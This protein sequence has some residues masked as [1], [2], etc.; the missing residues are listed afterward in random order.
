MCKYIHLCILGSV[1]GWCYFCRRKRSQ[2]WVLKFQ[3]ISV[4]HTVCTCVRTCACVCVCVCVYVC[5]TTASRQYTR[6]RARAHALAK[7]KNKMRLNGRQAQK[8]HTNRNSNS[9]GNNTARSFLVWPGQFM[10]RKGQTE[11]NLRPGT[12]DPPKPETRSPILYTLYHIPYTLYPIPYTRCPI[13]IAD[14]RAPTTPESHT[15]APCKQWPDLWRILHTFQIG[16]ESGISS[17]NFFHH[18]RTM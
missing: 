3:F 16:F 2:L 10:C 1:V 4:V 17:Y 9:N 18:E 6:K 14:T 15:K 5:S 11:T 12:G 7:M 8:Q 13:P